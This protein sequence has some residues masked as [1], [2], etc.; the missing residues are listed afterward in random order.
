MARRSSLLALGLLV[1]LAGC[2]TVR[3]HPRTEMAA[4]LNRVDAVERQMT[5][6]LHTVSQAGAQFAAANGQTSAIADLASGARQAELL[7]AWHQIRTLAGRLAAI[8]AP[9][10]AQELKTLLVRLA[11]EQAQLTRETAHLDVFLPR[12]DAALRPLAPATRA[13]ERVLSVTRAAG[14]SAVKAV[15]A[16]KAQALRQFQATLAGVGTRLRR[17]RPPPVSQPSYRAQ[18]TAVDGMGAD[19]GKL[20]TALVSGDTVRI[21]ALLQ[22]FDRAALEPQARAVQKA[23]TDAATAY[24]RATSSLSA[25]AVQVNVTRARLNNTIQ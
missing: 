24:D 21:P 23:E 9:A 6:P 3:S 22:S 4:Y 8:P 14:K 16:R 19:A 10:S 15:Y 5:A 2:G 17:L 13:L 20:A 11:D 25:L 18:L 1:V 12:F 7:R